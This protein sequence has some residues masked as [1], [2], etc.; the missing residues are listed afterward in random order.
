MSGTW[1]S[2][3][4]LAKQQRVF[5]WL[6]FSA[7]LC[8]PSCRAPRP[9][10]CIGLLLGCPRSGSCLPHVLIFLWGILEIQVTSGTLLLKIL[11]HLPMI[12]EKRLR[13]CM[14]CPLTNPCLPSPSIAGQFPAALASLPFALPPPPCQACSCPRTFALAAP[15]ARTLFSQIH[16]DAA[17]PP[18]GLCP[19]VTSLERP[20]LAPPS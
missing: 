9:A 6:L 2:A 13:P 18:S 15:S 16:T 17:P 7:P 11:Q 14:T 19:N 8:R 1:N 12:W 4:P 20:S 5:I 3:R 10:S